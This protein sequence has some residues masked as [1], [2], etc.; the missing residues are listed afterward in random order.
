MRRLS[1]EDNSFLAWESDVQPQHTIKAVVLDPQAGHVP[2]TFETVRAAVPGLVDR[3]QP[4]QWQLLSPRVGAGRPWWITRSRGELDYHVRRAAA[5]A[6]GGD[7][8]LGAA[9]AELFEDQLDRRRPPWQLWYVDGLADGRIALVLKIHHAVADGVASLQLLEQFYSADPAARLPGPSTHPA[10]DE[11]RPAAGVW[12]AMVARHQVAALRRFPRIIA[13]TARVTGTIRRRQKSGQPGYAEAFIPPAQPFNEPLTA[14]RGFAYRACDM[15]QI[16][17][18]SKAFGVSINDVFLALCAAVLR[19]YQAARGSISDDPMTA[20]VPVSMRP[21][22]GDR[23]GNKVARWNVEIATQIA[24][25]V[26]RLRAI[27]AATGT[28]REVQ[29]ERD[30]WLQHDW[31]EYWPLFKFYSRVLPIVGAKVKKRPMF[32]M[33]ASNMH[34]P[35]QRLYFGGA[36][37]EKL[38]STGPLVFPMGLNMTGW[39]YQGQMQI[40]VLSCADQVADPQVIAD[41]LPAAL[42]EL[43]A[44]GESAADTVTG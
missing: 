35:Q 15:A 37:V 11:H 31:M 40:C 42:A 10:A 23:W 33:I 9:I 1:G 32:S 8:E 18:V 22:D 2:L 30:A 4:L 16:K 41:G 27:A 26:D 38:I 43:V 6:P 14:K 7:V 20:V 21:E 12:F 19:E 3:V 34:G 25:P 13:R 24:D 29:A 44:R 36:P 17:Q 5:A 39:S 28:A